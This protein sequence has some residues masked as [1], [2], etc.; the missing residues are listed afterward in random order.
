MFSF[1][2]LR[3]QA[4]ELRTQYEAM[5]QLDNNVT[6]YAAHAILVQLPN[7]RNHTVYGDTSP[8]IRM[9][10]FGVEIEDAA[11][12]AFAGNP[13]TRKVYDH[14][15]NNRL[16][17]ITWFAFA[18]E[19][20][21]QPAEIVG[22]PRSIGWMGLNFLAQR[23]QLE[24]F[25]NVSSHTT[26]K[27]LNFLA[28][29][30]LS[31]VSMIAGRSQY[32]EMLQRYGRF[33]TQEQ[34]KQY[35]GLS[36]VLKTETNLAFDTVKKQWKA[37][38]NALPT[39]SLASRT[40]GWEVEVPDAKGVLAPPTVEKGND[41]SLRSYESDQSDCECDCGECYY[42]ECDCEH[43]DNGNSD[44]EHCQSADC[45]GADMAEFRTIGGMTRT[46]HPG[47]YKL[48]NDLN[49]IQAEKNDTAG[50]HIHVWA[51]DLTTN[52]V[53]QVMAIYKATEFIW[54]VMAGRAGNQYSG[55][56]D[57]KAIGVAIRSKDPKLNPDKCR[58]VNVSQLFT[59]RRTI[60]FRQLDCNLNAELITIW[61][62]IMRGMVETAKRGAKFWDF[63]EVQDLEDVIA[64][65]AKFG[66]TLHDEQPGLYIPGA[67]NDMREIAT[68]EH[69]QVARW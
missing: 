29:F 64:V 30:K 46:K 6:A 18:S 13:Q 8:A 49:D 23:S 24:T 62:W 1:T 17:W 11:S 57:T 4:L 34:A 16:K 60:E 56:I 22:A 38:Y 26:W 39:N 44:P 51:G 45:S 53:G 32:T 61:A 40:W 35:E 27:T 37:A 25:E 21:R 15:L 7:T 5:H 68:V 31:K 58:A 36:N 48:C 41:G 10:G 20:D 12:N 2:E 69:A 28:T 43:C 54:N 65:Y 33:F 59:A 55:Y 50:T 42:H 14:L 9:S 19:I 66:Y 3:R 47:L 52:Q 67:K 63:R